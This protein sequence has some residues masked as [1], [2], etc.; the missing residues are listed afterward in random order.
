MERVNYPTTF[1][2]GVFA[3]HYIKIDYSYEKHW[4]RNKR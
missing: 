4:G 1:Q 2:W 3:L